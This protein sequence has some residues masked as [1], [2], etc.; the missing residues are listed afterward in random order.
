MADPSRHGGAGGALRLMAVMA[1]PDDESLG[2]GGVLARYAAEGVETFLVT[3][4]RGQRGRYKGIPPGEGHPGPVAMARIREAELRAAAEVLG[5][6]ELR[7]LDYMDG[8]LDQADPRE[9]A[10]RIAAELRRARPQVVVTFGP[11][12]AYGHPDH[13]AIC[14]FTTAALVMAADPAAAVG[15]GA[16]APHAVSKL[17]YMA[18]TRASWEAYQEAFKRLVSVVDGVEREGQPY[19]DWRITT[20]IDTRDYWPTVWRAVRCHESQIAAYEK[21]RHL[22]PE[23]HEGLWGSQAFYRAC[24]TVNGGRRRETDLFEGLRDPAPVP[25]AAAK[26]AGEEE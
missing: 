8:E 17:Y 5:L 18:S 16:L 10:G 11:E 12:G 24:S 1:H 26:P 15:D 23:H 19:P 13:I 14:Q 2:V 22:S 9:A 6:R 7:L 25:R 3:A 4:T 20:R 21:L